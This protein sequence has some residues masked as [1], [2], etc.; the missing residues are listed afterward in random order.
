MTRNDDEGEATG[1]LERLNPFESISNK[2]SLPAVFF[3][4]P[5]DV[6]KGSN[7]TTEDD[8]AVSK[9]FLP[10]FLL[11]WFVAL[12]S[13]LDRTAMSVAIL[14]L[15]TEYHLTDTVKGA[16][17]SVFSIGYGLAII[18]SG[19]LAA[20][21]SPRLIM[22]VGVTIWSTATFGTPIAASLIQLTQ[23]SSI[24]DA[25]ATAALVA[26]NVA[27]LLLIRAV[28]GSAESVVMPS[29]QRLISNWVPASK[30]SFAIAMLYS[31]FQFG[32][33]TAYSL[34]P[35]VIDNLGGWRGMFYFYGVIGALWLVPWAFLSKDAPDALPEPETNNNIIDINPFS[36][37]K[38][39][40]EQDDQEKSAFDEATAVFK[41]APWSKFTKSKSVWA[42][43]VAH[44]ASNWG[45][46]NFL[47]W[48]PTFYAEEYGLDVR[49][50]A[51][52]SVFPSIAGAICGISSGFL[53][54]KVISTL[55]GDVDTVRTNVRKAAQGIALLGPATCLLI[56]ASHIPENPLVAQAL[57]MGTVGL[58]ACSA[59]GFG[60]A[61]QEKA[62]VQ[63]SGLLYSITTLP[64][65][66]FGSLG[67]Y[68]T[69]QVL[70]LTNQ[71]WSQVYSINAGIDIIGALAFIGFY[72]SRKEFD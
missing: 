65:V 19:L 56:L 39:E 16:I 2:N 47:S 62:G 68:V 7:G 60:S 43:I 48:T 3:E 50:S 57:L 28:I 61:P 32:T 45:L 11:C 26:T 37:K 9:D 55:D 41:E 70:D 59:A 8:V 13:M 38:V 27:P 63:W 52:L 18:P 34:S 69:G 12:L 42:L 71:D 23:S 4:D 44:A 72:N 30:K 49:Q 51:F 14:P 66:M 22:A 1:V 17:S 33:I 24:D 64:G 10:T 35:W 6:I 36:S 21:V 5:T 25:A 31:G 54:D 58:Q 46:Y 40:I 15:S 20:S 53:A 67:V 29:I